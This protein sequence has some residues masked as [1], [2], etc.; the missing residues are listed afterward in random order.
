MSLQTEPGEDLLNAEALP[1]IYGDNSS[2]DVSEG[3]KVINKQVIKSSLGNSG[4]HGNPGNIW[5]L[6]NSKSL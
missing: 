3:E 2:M 6:E 4:F 5:S 1:E